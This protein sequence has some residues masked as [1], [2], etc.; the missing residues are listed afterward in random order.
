MTEEHLPDDRVGDK[1]ERA[2]RA[3]FAGVLPS[4]GTPGGAW[5]QEAAEEDEEE[6]EEEGE[7]VLPGEGEQYLRLGL[8][9]DDSWECSSVDLG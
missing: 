8:K 7:Q 2:L 5:T 6:E 1:Q 9:A 3:V 4:T